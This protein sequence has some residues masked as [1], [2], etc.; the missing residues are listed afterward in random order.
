MSTKR[1]KHSLKAGRVKYNRPGENMSLKCQP[2]PTLRASNHQN[3]Y[4]GFIIRFRTFLVFQDLF[5]RIIIPTFGNPLRP[6]YASSS[7]RSNRLLHVQC[8]RFVLFPSPYMLKQC[9]GRIM[10]NYPLLLTENIT[11][12]K[13]QP[14]DI[15]PTS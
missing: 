14:S 7:N 11:K 6:V 2:S 3:Q 8:N 1:R 15:E 12:T 10:N 13:V 5:G 4:K 9:H